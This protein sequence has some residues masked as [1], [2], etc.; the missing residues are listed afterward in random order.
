[1]ATPRYTIVVSGERFTFT[2]DQLESDSRNYFSTYFFG[3]FAE[4][5][6]GL[7]ELVIEKDAQ[8][9]K[10]IQA[11][12]RGYEI[13]PLPNSAIPHY[14]TRQGATT[15]LLLEAQFY[16]LERLEEKIRAVQYEPS[17]TGTPTTVAKRYKFGVSN[18]TFRKLAVFDKR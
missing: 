7:R 10:L 8:L 18:R 1:M 14:M 4:G 9:F 6:Q 15:N 17:L 5:S 12:L 13:F 16:G 3:G 2:R 11:H